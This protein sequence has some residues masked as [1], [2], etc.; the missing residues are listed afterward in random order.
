[1]PLSPTTPAGR[2]L[3]WLWGSTWPDRCRSSLD[4]YSVVVPA[5]KTLRLIEPLDTREIIDHT[6][7]DA[8]CT[9]VLGF[10]L[11]NVNWTNASGSAQTVVVESSVRTGATFDCSQD[12]SGCARTWIPA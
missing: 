12:E 11:S 6:I 4:T 9:N 1:M 2:Q 3:P 5:G 8:G 7:W 10:G